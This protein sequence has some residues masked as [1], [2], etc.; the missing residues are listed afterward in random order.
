MLC[1]RVCVRTFCESCTTVGWRLFRNG[2]SVGRHVPKQQV[3]V[4]IESRAANHT[5]RVTCC[6]SYL[7]SHVL[8][9]VLIESRVANRTYRV[10]CCKSYGC[11]ANTT[12]VAENSLLEYSD[13]KCLYWMH[14]NQECRHAILECTCMLS[15]TH[16]WFTRA[17]SMVL[18]RMIKYLFNSSTPCRVLS[19]GM[20]T[21]VWQGQQL[22]VQ[23]WWFT[24]HQW[25]V[26]HSSLLGERGLGLVVHMPSGC[27][28]KINIP[29]P[30]P[31][32][33]PMQKFIDRRQSRSLFILMK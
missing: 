27:V 15:V 1:S 31:W 18:L 32:P 6:K 33:S 22:L 13:E 17:K 25:I 24:A 14:Q 4:L 26:I 12:A 9:I 2:V 8:Q 5:Y 7:S 3:A 29:W 20:P 21:H 11:I 28:A 16:S 19:S 23:G 10:T 30:W